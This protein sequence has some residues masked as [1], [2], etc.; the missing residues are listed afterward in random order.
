MALVRQGYSLHAVARRLSCHASSV[1]RWHDAFA[2]RPAGAG[3]QVAEEGDSTKPGRHMA[4]RAGAEPAAPPD[5]PVQPQ[6]AGV[7]LPVTTTR[8]GCVPTKCLT[9]GAQLARFC[10]SSRNIKA[11][12]PA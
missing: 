6:S 1:L 5:Y 10:T 12:R 8:T 2:R 7:E 11:P 4:T 9:C 3:P